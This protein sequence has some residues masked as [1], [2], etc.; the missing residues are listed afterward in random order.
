MTQGDLLTKRENSAEIDVRKE[1]KR[2]WLSRRSSATSAMKVS[3]FPQIFVF[4]VDHHSS[5]AEEEHQNTWYNKSELVELRQKNLPT[6]RLM[7]SGALKND[8]EEHCVRGLE[9][10]VY[11]RAMERKAIRIRAREAVFEEQDLQEWSESK[12]PEGLAQCYI[13]ASNP[14]SFQAHK[15]GLLDELQAFGPKLTNTI[16]LETKTPKSETW[17]LVQRNKGK[18]KRDQKLLSAIFHDYICT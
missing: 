11:D 1:T 18:Q 12:D 15:I 13:E 7:R 10:R 3:F 14:C 9:H 2:R 8:T 5:Y 16:C 4:E 6:I 17:S